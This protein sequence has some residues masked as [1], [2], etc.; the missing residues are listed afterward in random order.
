MIAVIEHLFNQKFVMD[1]VSNVLKPGGKVV[2]TTPTPFGNDVVHRVGATL[3]LFA[4]TAMNDW[5][6]NLQP[7]PFQNPCPR[8]RA[9][10][11]LPQ[12]LSAV[13]PSDCSSRKTSFVGHDDRIKIVMKYWREACQ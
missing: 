2:V 13:L 8:S 7:A 5:N 11:P 4:K 9:K 6:R 12:V 1:E 3:G 10:I